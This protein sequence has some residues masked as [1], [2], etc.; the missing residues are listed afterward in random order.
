MGLG[1]LQGGTPVMPDCRC[2]AALSRVAGLYAGAGTAPGAMVPPS[3]AD[4]RSGAS[5]LS[6]GSN[7]NAVLPHLLH[8]A[9]DAEATLRECVLD[10]TARDLIG[11]PRAR[12]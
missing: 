8:I 2:A 5:R 10:A 11:L 1:H 4:D 6:P 9:G 12:R 7:W 3:Q